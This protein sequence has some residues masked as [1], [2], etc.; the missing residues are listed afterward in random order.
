MQ[1]EDVEVAT[2][3][4]WIKSIADVLKRS[5]RRL[6]HPVNTRHESIYTYEAKSSEVL[7]NIQS[8]SEINQ[9][10]IF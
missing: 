4:E 3:L 7:R 5:I 6:K 10:W 9:M 1:K 2:F 8:R